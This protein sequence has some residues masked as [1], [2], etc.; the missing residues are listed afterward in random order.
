MN[1]TDEILKYLLKA[2]DYVSGEEIAS[3]FAIS[4]SAVWKMVRKLS[5]SGIKIDSKPNKG[6]KIKEKVCFVNEVAINSY[7]DDDFY[8]ISC[9]KELPSTNTY[10]KEH[11][12]DLESGTVVFARYQSAGRGRMNRSFYSPLDTGLYFSILVKP[13]T[14][15]SSSIYLTVIAAISCLEGIKEALGIKL[16]IKWVNDLYKDG[17][18][19][20][21]ILSEGSIDID[22]N[23]LSSCIIGIG[24]NVCKPVSGFCQELDGIASY[25]VDKC[26][27]NM[28]VSNIL[29]AFK[30]YYLDYINGDYSFINIY[31]ENQFIIG[32]RV[33][34]VNLA[35]GEK[36]IVTVL[37]VNDDCSLLVKEDNNT[38]YSINS[39]EVRLIVNN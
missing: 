37:Q 35:S 21:G 20:G 10:L 32:K 14:L 17:K 28:V 23:S 24:I 29:K 4:R 38:I 8:K 30:K 2:S 27:L 36:K 1:K 34:S 18:K 15:A 13:N 9:F 7:L 33:E 31:K 39:G 22:H 25:L 12:D 6:Y 11:K 19:V 5:E 3:N 16:D 26:D